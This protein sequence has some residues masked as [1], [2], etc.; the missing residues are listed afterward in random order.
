MQ[1]VLDAA[2]AEEGV[3]V[4]AER[5]LVF[6]WGD[7][8]VRGGDEVVTRGVD[9]A[10][11]DDL[12]G[13]VNHGDPTLVVEGAVAERGV[14]TR[15]ALG[16]DAVAAGHAPP[17]AAVDVRK[18]D[19]QPRSVD[20]RNHVV[21]EGLHILHN[22]RV[23]DVHDR[24]DGIRCGF[25]ALKRNVAE[26]D[27][28][29]RVL[30]ILE[31]VNA[32]PVERAVHSKGTVGAVLNLDCL[33]ALGVRTTRPV[34]N[35]VVVRKLW[36]GRQHKVVRHV[37]H[38]ERD[39]P[40]NFARGTRKDAGHAW[41]RHAEE[42]TAAV[43]DDDGLVVPHAREVDAKVGVIGNKG[44]VATGGV[45]HP[46]IRAHEL[47]KMILFEG[48]GGDAASASSGNNA[49]GVHRG[50]GAL[51][52]DSGGKGNVRAPFRQHLVVHL[53][54]LPKRAGLGINTLVRAAC[55]QGCLCAGSTELHDI[56]VRQ[57]GAVLEAVE[58][59][60]GPLRVLGLELGEG[61]VALGVVRL[62]QTL[63]ALHFATTIEG[64][65]NLQLHERHAHVL[66][67]EVIGVVRHKESAAVEVHVRWD[68]R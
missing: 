22:G 62:K 61:Q 60:V 24:A 14:Q 48:A 2:A 6:L 53:P 29:A 16:A 51:T 33:L 36:V 17:I 23:H 43:L 26:G 65:I 38:C 55:V 59:V 58:V 30:K 1:D 20:V 49:G 44:A 4:E 45:R 8:L 11:R 13:E 42:L 47:P 18:R 57:N 3:V 10:G 5:V 7:H 50:G 52:I 25:R 15:V 32:G 66:D 9:E 64:Q 31:H 28:D 39:A 12:T 68:L 34:D 35:V 40:R 37:R 56:I 67:R 27:G 19:A 63:P 41:V 46:R 54:L 21:R